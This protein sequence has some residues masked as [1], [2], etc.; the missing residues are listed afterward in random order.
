MRNPLFL[1]RCTRPFPKLPFCWLRIMACSN[2]TSSRKANASRVGFEEPEPSGPRRGL[3]RAPYGSPL[4]PRNMT[5]P[6]WSMETMRH[7]PCLIQNLLGCPGG[8]NAFVATC[9]LAHTWY[10]VT[11]DDALTREQSEAPVSNAMTPTDEPI[12][13]QP[14]S[15][16]I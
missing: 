7:L 3:I 9:R 14:A 11:F 1:M 15:C 13:I 12:D 2:D 16:Q 4:R 6:D 5:L 10:Y 8:I